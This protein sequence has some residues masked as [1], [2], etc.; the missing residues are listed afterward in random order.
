MLNDVRNFGTTWNGSG[1]G[2]DV[3]ALGRRGPVVQDL[4][5]K[6]VKCILETLIVVDQ[7]GL[8]SPG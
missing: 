6:G 5:I 8:G 4:L 2:A 3:V 7:V 1:P